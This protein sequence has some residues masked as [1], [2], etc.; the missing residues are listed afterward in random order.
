MIKLTNLKTMKL[1]TTDDLL[2]IFT[3]YFA[4]QGLATQYIIYN[5]L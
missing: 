5:Y 1:Y 4:R 3:Y 2:V